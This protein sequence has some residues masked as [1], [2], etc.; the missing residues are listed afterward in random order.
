MVSLSG[1]PLT[2]L[3]ARN[4][5]PPPRVIRGLERKLRLDE[6]LLERYWHWLGDLVQGDLGPTRQDLDLPQEIVTRFGITLRL[7]AAAMIIAV[8]LAV[9]VGV[10]SAVKQYSAVDHSFTFVGFLFLAMP[11]FWFAILLK[12]GAIAFNNRFGDGDQIF[13]TIG[14]R[15]VIPSG[16][17]WSDILGHLILPTAVLAMTSFAAW[18]RYQRASMLEVLN[19]DYVRLARAKGLS[20]R[21]VMTR[22]ALRTALIPLTTVTALDLGAIIGG[23]VITETV[24]QWQGAG[25]MLIENIQQR[26]VYAVL[27]WLLVSGIVII[28]FNLIADL[29]YAVLDPRIRYE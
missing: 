13:Y 6:P 10:V 28:V 11:T 3:R 24:F 15:S 8:I 9:V 1:D 18:S 26:E 20:R 27:A 29:L 23:A 12:Q 14:D 2:D 7:V 19:S 25:R 21:R 17:L 5:Q 16:P 4:P 22:H